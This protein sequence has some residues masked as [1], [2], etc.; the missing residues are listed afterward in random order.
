MFA[1]TQPVSQSPVNWTA[2]RKSK[3]GVKEGLVS[4]FAVLKAG[5]H[6]RARSHCGTARECKEGRR[7]DSASRTCLNQLPRPGGAHVLLSLSIHSLNSGAGELRSP[8]TNPMT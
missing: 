6:G 1:F 4:G 8:G 7:A 5:D 2:A 3:A